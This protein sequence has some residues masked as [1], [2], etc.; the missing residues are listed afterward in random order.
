M[1]LIIIYSYGWVPLL[2]RSHISRLMGMWLSLIIV[3]SYE[4]VSLSFIHMNEYDYF[5]FIWMSFSII[6]ESYLK[7]H[8]YMNESHYCLFIWMSII[9][10]YSY[11][12]EQLLF[13]HMNESQYHKGVISQDSWVY[14]WISSLLIHTNESY[15]HLFIWMSLIIIKES[16]LKTHWYKNESHYD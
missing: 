6:K 16:Y 4:W 15:Y 14:D 12:W 13:I 10:I 2:Y 5:L 3:Y 8:G 9:I 1:S 11:E 7:T